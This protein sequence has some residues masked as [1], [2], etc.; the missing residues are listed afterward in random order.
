MSIFYPAEPTSSK[1]GFPWL[2]CKDYSSRMNDTA[3]KDVKRKRNTATPHFFFQVVSTQFYR[4]KMF[5]YER[6]YIKH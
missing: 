1:V 4:M 3:K 5:V 6:A 2:K